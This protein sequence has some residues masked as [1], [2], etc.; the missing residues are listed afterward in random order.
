M[1]ETTEI[2]PFYEQEG[3]ELFRPLKTIKGSDQMRLLGRLKKMGLI[4]DDAKRKTEAKPDLDLE[5]LADLVDYVGEKFTFD[6]KA[7]DEFTSGEDGY[8]RAISLTVGFAQLVGESKSSG[9]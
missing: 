4:S 3:H 6:P 1:A 8:T 5:E 2:D 7:F 9:N